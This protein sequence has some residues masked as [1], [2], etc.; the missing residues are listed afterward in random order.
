MDKKTVY[1]YVGAILIG[2]AYGVLLMAFVAVHDFSG[3]SSGVPSVPQIAVPYLKL[4]NGVATT[5]F[6]PYV[7]LQNKGIGL[8]FC[9]ILLDHGFLYIALPAA[10]SVAFL[11]FKK[12]RAVACIQKSLESAGTFVIFVWTLWMLD[13]AMKGALPVNQRFDEMLMYVLSTLR[14]L[15]EILIIFPVLPIILLVSLCV[16]MV[17]WKPES[18]V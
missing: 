1:K 14:T 7:E 9:M 11:Q 5:F 12:V 3:L 16:N 6:D 17:R 18:A 13:L 10:L 2:A 15:L 8:R 4:R